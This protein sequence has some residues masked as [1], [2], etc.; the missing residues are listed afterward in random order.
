M[1]TGPLVLANGTVVVG[2]RTGPGSSLDLTPSGV[3][4][5]SPDCLVAR[6]LALRYWVQPLAAHL[7]LE[8]GLAVILKGARGGPA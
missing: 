6:L 5:V 4:G 3:L 1:H 8:L 7:H 2:S